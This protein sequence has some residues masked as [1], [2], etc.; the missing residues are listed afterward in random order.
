MF[1][2]IAIVFGVLI[3]ALLAYAASRPDSFRIERTASIEAPASEVFP[4][5][6]DLHKW[7][8]WSPYEKK[9][10]AM[11]RHFRGPAS[12][13]GAI[14]EWEGDE[15]V[16]V[17]RMEIVEAAEPSRVRIRLDFF[18]PFEAHNTADFVLQ[19]QGG[20]TQV[21]WAMYGPSPFM[22]KLMQVFF[23]MDGMV[24][25]DFEAGLA[26]LKAMAER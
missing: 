12:G 6:V 24:G 20:A 25:P 15:N 9:D 7:R 17:G 26:N 18:R 23:S 3:A 19:E 1:K 16:G 11:R 10:P 21:T 5:I 14:Y 4:L 2:T 13:E 22:A 8:E